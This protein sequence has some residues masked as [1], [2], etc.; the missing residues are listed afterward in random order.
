MSRNPPAGES[1]IYP[2]MF[3][4]MAWMSTSWFFLDKKNEAKKSRLNMA[5]LFFLV[6]S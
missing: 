5:L 3:D 4:F 2:L 1:F 6:Y